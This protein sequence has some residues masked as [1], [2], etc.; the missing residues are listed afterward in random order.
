MSVSTA[1]EKKQNEEVLPIDL[2]SP[3]GGKSAGDY[4]QPYIRWLELIDECDI[5]VELEEML[6]ARV[7]SVFPI[8]YCTNNK[9]IFYDSNWA[10]CILRKEGKEQYKV[11]NWHEMDK[12]DKDLDCGGDDSLLALWN[13]Y[14]KYP[15]MEFMNLV[16][17]E[18]ES[19]MNDIGTHNVSPK[20][21]LFCKNA[22]ANVQK[23]A[24]SITAIVLK[25]STSQVFKLRDVLLIPLDNVDCTKVDS[26]TLASVIVSI[27]KDKSTCRVAV[28][29]GLLPHAY[30]YHVIK[31]VPEASNNLDA[32]DLWDA[33]DNWRS[34][35]KITKREAACFISPVGGQGVI[36]CTA[37]EAAPQTAVHARKRVGYAAAVATGIACVAKIHMMSS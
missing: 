20:H 34:L 31:P 13:M 29:Q 16:C 36:H 6:H 12:V 8:I 14:Y 9:N 25:K 26:A 4:T 2:T 24:N 30:V 21:H 1:V 37:G 7:N 11:L 35:P 33:Y 15:T 5:P 32:M 22:T 19:T 28:K 18:L 23:K 3:S 17:I 27:N 10:P